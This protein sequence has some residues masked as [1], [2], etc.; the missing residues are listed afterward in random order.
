MTAVF[1][2]QWKRKS[3]NIN[4]FMVKYVKNVSDVGGELGSSYLPSGHA[5]DQTGLLN[6]NSIL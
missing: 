1:L 3:C 6:D 2:S 4:V 5:T